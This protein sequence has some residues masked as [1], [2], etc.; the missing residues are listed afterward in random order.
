LSD[1]VLEALRLRA[2]HAC[3]LGYP[4]VEVAVVLGVCRETV[5]RWWSAYSQDG[6]DGLPQERTGRPL[7][8]GR[9][10]TD[11]Q[12]EHLQG[13]IDDHFPEQLGIASALWTRRAVQ[14]LIHRTYALRMPLRTV[15]E[16]L[17]RWGYTPKRP[18]RQTRGQ[19]PAEVRRWLTE[20]YPAIAAR[21]A[22]EGAEIHWGDETGVASNEPRGRGYARIGAT[23]KIEV[24]RDRFRV[25][26]ISTITNQDKVRFLTFTSTFT[27]PVF[28]AFLGRLLQET[29]RKIFLIVDPHPVHDA[30][31]VA[32]WLAQHRDRIELFTLPRRAPELNPDEYL[33]NDLKGGVNAERMPETRQELQSNVQHFMTK[34]QGLPQRVKSYFQHPKVQYAATPTV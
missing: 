24:T 26:Q 1:E 12:A 27:T 25:N 33:N 8:S 31:A 11:E 17:R 13:L 10:L 20:T 15:G 32:A 30:A 9:T 18:S 23:P 4:E 16:Y 14:D 29:A 6:V 28:L 34:L 5:S 21:A 19:V 3:E 2:V 22:R 7:G